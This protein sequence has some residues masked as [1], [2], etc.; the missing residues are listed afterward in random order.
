MLRYLKRVVPGALKRKWRGFL[1]KIKG[2]LP[3]YRQLQCPICESWDRKF[4]SFG[5]IPRPNARCP[6]CNA[7]ERHRLVW[8]FFHR[9]TDL[10]A[11]GQKKMLHFAPEPIF[12]SRF[13]QLPNL[14]YTTADLNDPAVMVKADITNL[15]FPDETFDVIYCSHVLE[16]VPDDRK[17]MRE[18][19]RVLKQTGY[20][21]I[22]VPITD[23]STFEDP[24][25]TD[26][27]EREKLFGQWDHVRRYGP[28]FVDR[29]RDAGFD[30]TIY[31]TAEV[32]GSEAT[33]FAIPPDE[34][35][36]YLC[37]RK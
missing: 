7:L 37:R 20:A 34:G 26:P 3:Y 13:S 27:K 14:D 9:H 24:S 30:V 10:F 12:S 32:A 35:P 31:T 28:D 25:I 18:C 15:P 36:V 17:A 33:R 6:W 21:I 23:T 19:C 2:N 11:G 8:L 16:H 5:L 22:L 4:G 29:L 1:R